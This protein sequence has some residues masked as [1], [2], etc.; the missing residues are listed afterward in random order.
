MTA[1]EIRLLS[2][3]NPIQQLLGESDKLDE[4]DGECFKQPIWYFRSIPA[5]LLRGLRDGHLLVVRGH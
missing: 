1:Q 3:L 4:V 2:A 5:I